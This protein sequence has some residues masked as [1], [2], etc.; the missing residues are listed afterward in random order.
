MGGGGAADGLDVPEEQES[1]DVSSSGR[2]EVSPDAIQS[3]VRTDATRDT[4]Q[5]D[6]RTEVSPPPSP[7]DAEPILAVGET[8]EPGENQNG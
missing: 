5:D 1:D 8:E 4:S 7:E 2:V 3:A 6:Q